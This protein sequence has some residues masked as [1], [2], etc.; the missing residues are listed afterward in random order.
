M[1]KLQCF[2]HSQNNKCFKNT[3]NKIFN[4]KE[5]KK[6]YQKRDFCGSKDL[7]T[8]L[9]IRVNTNKLSSN[10]REDKLMIKY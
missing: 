7:K 8:L 5:D 6:D 3:Q 4:K 2:L 10:S 1:N 9:V